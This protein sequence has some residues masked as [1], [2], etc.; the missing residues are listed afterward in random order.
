MKKKDKVFVPKYWLGFN[1]SIYY[2]AKPIAKF[3][4]EV[5]VS[6]VVGNE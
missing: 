3:M 5:E 6:E 4:E 2:Q 1:S